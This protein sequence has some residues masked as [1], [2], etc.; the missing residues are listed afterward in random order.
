MEEQYL[1]IFIRKQKLKYFGR[2]SSSSSSS[3]NGH[4]NFFGD[5]CWQANKT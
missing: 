1:E 4:I 5:F 2:G 3:S